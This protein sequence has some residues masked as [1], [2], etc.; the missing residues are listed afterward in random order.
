MSSYFLK[1]LFVVL[2][3]FLHTNVSILGFNS[4]SQ[5]S[6]VKCIKAEKQ[7]LLKFKH[8]ITDNSGMLSTWSDNS[9]NTDCCRWEGIECNNETGHVQM[10]HL[11]GSMTHRLSGNINITSLLQLQNMEYLDLSNN[12][13]ISNQIPEHLDSFKN[14]RYLNLSYS[15]F[16]GRIPYELGNLSKLEYLDLNGN[17]LDGEIPYQLGN[18]SKLE[19]LDL[20]GND[21][22]GEIPYQLGNLSRLRYLDLTQNSFSEQSF[23]RLGIFLACILLDW[24]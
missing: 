7:A 20:K 10:L 3:C 13:F 18:L 1:I 22:D 2:L 15:R 8:G 19:Y 5:S 21:L 6:P 14:L 4:P 17:D 11:G 24:S 16:G 12:M 9:N 23:S